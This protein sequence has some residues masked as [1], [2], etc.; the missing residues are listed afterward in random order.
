MV[1]IKTLRLSFALKN[2]Y[3]VNSILYAIKQIPLLKKI[4][5]AS[6]YQMRGFKVFA[7]IISV[8]WEIISAFIGKLVYFFIMIFGILQLYELPSET[9]PQLFLHIL[10]LLSVNGAFMNTYMFNPTKDKYYAMILLGMDAKE[11][12]LI[13]YFYA[14][15]KV[16]LGFTLCGLLFGLLTG[17]PVWQCLLIP[18]YVAGIKI[19]VAVTE[20]R[21][22][23]KTG[24][25]MNENKIDK[26]KWFIVAVI[27]AAA[28]GIPALGCMIP[29]WVS[30]AVMIIGIL[31]GV[32]S[33]HKI[34]I[35]KHYRPM[36]KELLADA[37]GITNP[38]GQQTKI[39]RENSL[40]NISADATIESNKKGFEYLNELFIK[41][42]KKILWKSVKKIAVVCLGIIAVL[43]VVFQLYP[44]VKE[45]TN[46]VLM[47]ALPI[48]LF[49]MYIINR[50]TSF[51]QALFVNCDHSLLTYSFY[52]QP[53]Y[54]LRLFWIRL[55]EIIKINLLPASVIGFGLALLLFASGGT[56]D[57][58]NYAVLI[59]SM[60]C[61][62]MFFSVHYLTVYYLLQPYNAGTE[63]KSGM[64]QV[65]NM[66]VYG[67]CYGAMQA[68]APT[69]IFGI[70]T[71]VFC[72]LYCLVASLLVY[73]LAPKTFKIRA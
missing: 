46:K 48:S 40:K 72:V 28:Y 27:L 35:F 24:T 8:I 32:V 47:S 26:F 9:E 68:K 53:G 71:I 5:P 36:Y 30:I 23:E 42:H 29:V 6:I 15:V 13:N 57:P 22:F 60:L 16:L 55:R 39:I 44:E 45:A 56:E 14:I 21:A 50:G 12:T 41:R 58:M 31:L 38:S 64:Y 17:L 18:F 54:I 10:L 51:T 69:L 66:V 3:R 2:T 37:S 61:L 63:I 7:N 43:L 67:V 70:A 73:K 65:I 34:L 33:V 62:S 25:A 19:T 11:Y 20:L 4:I 1:M 59:V 49:V 52:K